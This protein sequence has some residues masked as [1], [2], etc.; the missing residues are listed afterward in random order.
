MYL[1]CLFLVQCPVHKLF[2]LDAWQQCCYDS[3][4]IKRESREAFE[5]KEANST[6]QFEQCSRPW[7]YQAAEELNSSPKWGYHAWYG[8]GGYSADLGYEEDTAYTVINHLQSGQWVDRQTRAIIVEFNIFNPVISALGACSFFFELLQTGQATALKHIDIIS[9]YNTDSILQVFLGLFLVIF[10]AMVFFKTAE[11][12]A[13]LVRQG[14]RCLCCVW[15]WLDLFHLVTSISLLVVSFFKSY[16]ISQTMQELQRNIFATINFQTAVLWGNV[17]NCIVAVLT[18]LTTVKLLQLTY[19]NMYTR[20]FSHALRIWM[21]DLFSFLVVLSIIFFAFLQSGI[22][23]F[24]S[25]NGRYSSFWPAF[26]Y[27]LEIVLGKV[28]ARPIKEL[29]KADSVLGYFFV[30]MLLV[31]ITILLMNLFIS[32]LNDAVSEANK[33][34]M[35]SESKH[36]TSE[37]QPDVST[38]NLNTQMKTSKLKKKQGNYIFFDQI[39]D[40]LKTVDLN[41]NLPQAYTLDKKLT[42]VLKLI[43]VS[44]KMDCETRISPAQRTTNLKPRRENG[45]AVDHFGRG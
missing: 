40:Q 24:G 39:S 17:E 37:N 5:Y 36:E 23:L 15:Y 3:Y 2:H 38:Y 45:E 33:L 7:V 18:F 8:G 44:L 22:L 19:F 43:D 21:R 11:I 42:A 41:H 31:G 28:K 13:T 4:S 1:I 35:N 30:V 16:H 10:I 9:L 27:Q 34:E 6:V 32:S 20:I 12:M 14:R 25:H 29:V 26:S